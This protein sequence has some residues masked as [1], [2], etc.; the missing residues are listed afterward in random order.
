MSKVT[1]DVFRGSP[2]TWSE[3]TKT[4]ARLLLVGERNLREMEARG[5]SPLDENG[6][7]RSL[8]ASTRRALGRR[9][10]VAPTTDRTRSA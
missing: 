10:S 2:D 6:V 7:P 4:L 1:I 5:E 9:S 3:S 8:S